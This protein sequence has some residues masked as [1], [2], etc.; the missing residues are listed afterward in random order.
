MEA[1]RVRCIIVK[2]RLKRIVWSR[3]IYQSRLAGWLLAGCNTRRFGGCP[4]GRTRFY[5]REPVSSR[6]GRDLGEKR[7][8][9][10]RWPNQVQRLTLFVPRR[11][12]ANHLAASIGNWRADGTGWDRRH[13]SE[14]V[15]ATVG[16]LRID[17]SFDRRFLT[18]RQRASYHCD[19]RANIGFG[20]FTQRKER[21]PLHIGFEDCEIELCR[22]GENTGH[23]ADCPISHFGDGIRAAL[24][25]APVGNEFAVV[26]DEKARSRP[27]QLARCVENGDQNYGGT[28][29]ACQCCQTRRLAFQRLTRE[30]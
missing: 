29:A 19:S 22:G 23:V 6:L 21:N 14:P 10:A 12:N 28:D 27:Q 8:H 16:W 30:R 24:C 11:D 18:T 13:D 20:S 3:L 7:L 4:W 2:M 9:H 15:S 25:R 17:C 5:H 26:R 1:A